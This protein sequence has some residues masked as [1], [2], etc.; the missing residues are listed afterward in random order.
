MWKL[1]CLFGG[2][3]ILVCGCG[4]SPEAKLQDAVAEVRAGRSDSIDIGATPI[5]VVLLLRKR[6]ICPCWQFFA[7]ARHDWPRFDGGGSGVL[8]I[9]RSADASRQ[10]PRC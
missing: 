6:S 10:S 3:L 9:V 4:R 8:A 2:L 1:C 5:S 7:F